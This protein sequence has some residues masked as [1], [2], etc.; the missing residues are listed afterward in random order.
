MI[1]ENGVR[2]PGYQA[3]PPTTTS[4]NLAPLLPTEGLSK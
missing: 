1:N 4:N 2:G 3:K